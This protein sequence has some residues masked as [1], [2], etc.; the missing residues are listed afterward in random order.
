MDVLVE[1]QS[2]KDLQ[3]NTPPREPWQGTC[4]ALHNHHPKRIQKSIERLS[5]NKHHVHR[6]C[7]KKKRMLNLEKTYQQ[8][9]TFGEVICYKRGDCF[10]LK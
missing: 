8:N 9:H 10:L 2:L 4:G 5:R 7:L 6:P 1:A 3:H